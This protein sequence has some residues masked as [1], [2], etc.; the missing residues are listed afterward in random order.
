MPTTLSL[1]VVG[2]STENFP[3]IFV[4]S[5][6]TLLICIAGSGINEDEPDKSRSERIYVSL[7]E[8]LASRRFL[9]VYR[10]FLEKR[11]HEFEPHFTLSPIPS[12][13][14][15]LIAKKYTPTLDKVDKDTVSLILPPSHISLL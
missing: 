1:P 5:V 4:E 11:M 8:H 12:G 6:E 15:D 2:V 13:I 10:E 3:S 9:V 14:F 7:Q